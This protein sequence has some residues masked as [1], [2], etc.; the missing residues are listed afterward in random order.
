MKGYVTV[1]C[2]ISTARLRQSRS[3]PQLLRGGQNDRISIRMLLLMRIQE[4]LRTGH[5]RLR[6]SKDILTPEDGNDRLSRNVGKDL[7]LHAA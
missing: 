7:P 5:A 3:C 1:E 6:S 4:Y 2:I